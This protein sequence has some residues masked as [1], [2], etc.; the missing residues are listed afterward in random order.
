MFDYFSKEKSDF[1]KKKDKS[2]KGCVDKDIK[3]IADEIN[4]KKDYYTTSS[5][6]G[7]IVLLEMKSK[8]KDECN[9]IFANHD[10]VGLN[11]IINA[12]TNYYNKNNSIKKSNQNKKINQIWFKQQPLILHVAS[13]NLEA[14]NKLLEVSRRIFR[15]AG[16]IGIT[17][18]KAMIEIIGDEKI[19]TIIA[20]KDFVANESYIKELVKYANANFEENKKK[21]E[22]FLRIIRGNL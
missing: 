16:I 9:W 1:L 5:C 3:E 20:D 10:K 22:G 15:R 21:S 14:A 18:R 19:E 12:L 13:R 17:K 8:R 4:S 7:R 2:K 11:E 6:S